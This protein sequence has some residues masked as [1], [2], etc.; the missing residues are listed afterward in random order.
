M[1]S[2]L[3]TRSSLIVQDNQIVSETVP[4]PRLPPSSTQ[5]VHFDVIC[6]TAHLATTAKALAKE[7]QYYSGVSCDKIIAV[8][9]LAGARMGSGGATLDALVMVVEHLSS[10]N[11]DP[12]HNEQRLKGK[13]ILILHTGG[14][15]YNPASWLPCMTGSCKKSQ[16]VLGAARP[17]LH[18]LSLLVR[19]GAARAGLHLLGLLV[20][21][22]AAQAIIFLLGLLVRDRK[23]SRLELREG[24]PCCS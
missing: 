9:D 19:D 15:T 4:L 14:N 22:V 13:R 6:I 5:M 21:D 23:G 17:G 16:S 3:G 12:H 8:S 2:G 11:G 20:R 18:L 24:I 1:I 10:L 7:L